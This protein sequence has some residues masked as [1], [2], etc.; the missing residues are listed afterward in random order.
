M[1]RHVLR[2]ALVAI[3]M[4]GTASGAIIPIGLGD[5]TTPAVLDFE[6]LS[7][8]PIA[9]N[10]PYFG[11]IDI[12]QVAVLNSIPGTDLLDSGADGNGLANVNGG[13][14]VVA[15][16][17]PM[18]GGNGSSALRYSFWFREDITRVGAGMADATGDYTFVFVH[19]GSVVGVRTF[20]DPGGSAPVYFESTVPFNK[21]EITFEDDPWQGW[22]VDNITGEMTAIPEPGS[23]ALLAVGGLGL[24][25]KRRRR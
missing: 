18:D 21:L 10:D 19:S 7:P 13:L 2:M 23:M 3:A 8:G 22:S 20:Y 15:P 14:S 4:I 25:W 5:F 24:W 9:P 6:S 11:L 17:G 16:N 12:T 1:S